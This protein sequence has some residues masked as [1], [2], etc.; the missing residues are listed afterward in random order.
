MAKQENDTA[1]VIL[2]VGLFVI[3]VI[4]MAVHFVRLETKLD[5]ICERVEC[6]EVP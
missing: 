3:L 1:R 2:I 5:A 4:S 6:V